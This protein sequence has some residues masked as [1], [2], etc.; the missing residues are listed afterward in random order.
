[1]QKILKLLLILS[2]LLASMPLI[3]QQSSSAADD[4]QPDEIL[5]TELPPTIVYLI[6][7]ES[8]GDTVDDTVAISARFEVVTLHE[9]DD[10]LQF[11]RLFPVEALI[12][13][14]SALD[15]VEDDVITAAYERG[16]VISVLNI[17]NERL[18]ELLDNPLLED[19]YTLIENDVVFALFFSFDMSYRSTG[20]S[21]VGRFSD[22]IESRAFTISLFI[23][24]EQ[25][26]Q[27]RLD[28]IGLDD[29]N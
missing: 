8:Q 9:W 19:R 3:A 23:D 17:S 20:G 11:E 29:A 26:R 24:I 16:V 25:S 18:V 15:F 6:A 2:V 27:A 28:A 14:P 10:Y 5:T 13:H 22:S 21:T 7:E 4:P 12:L 1:M